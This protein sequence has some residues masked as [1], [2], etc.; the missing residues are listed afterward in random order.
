METKKLGLD[1][2]I[3]ITGGLIATRVTDYA[4][5]ALW[6]ATPARERM[7]EPARLE[8]SSAKSAARI[9]LERTRCEVS[10]NNVQR[11]QR[12]IH[13]GLGL[14]WGPLFCLL[15]RGSGMTP[16]GAGVA[17]GAALSLIVDETM[18]PLLGITPPNRRFPASAHVRGLLT[19]IVWGLT[20][21]GVAESIHRAVGHPLPR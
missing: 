13:Y 16:V 8:N 6:S 18:N 17:S 19:H 7:R 1:I 21:A 14:M 15:R 20:A 10:E 4:E 12:A 11:A 5:K 9:L 3:G 2:A